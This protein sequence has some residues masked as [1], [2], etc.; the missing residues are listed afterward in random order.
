MIELKGSVTRITQENGAGIFP[1]DIYSKDGEVEKILLHHKTPQ[2]K[3][4]NFSRQE[5]AKMLNIPASGIMDLP[6][7]IGSTSMNYL[8]VPIRD[9]KTIQNI[10][11][12]YIE[13]AEFCKKNK[14]GL[15]TFTL[16][17]LKKG[18]STHDRTF[19]SVPGVYEDPVCGGGSG[20]MAAYLVRHRLIPVKDKITIISEQGYE[21]GRPSELVINLETADGSIKSVK[22]GG[23]AVTILEGNLVL[24]YRW[25]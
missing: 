24:H 16:E 12:N 11:P 25:Q 14:M 7:E 19:C 18:S 8:M 17:T 13:L 15:R 10:R 20:P 22:V 2:F 1:V 4:T 6:I 5:I 23:R 3:Q 21:A 9:L